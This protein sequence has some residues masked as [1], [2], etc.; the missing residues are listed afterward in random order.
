MTYCWIFDDRNHDLSSFRSDLKGFNVTVSS[1][2]ASPIKVTIVTLI[3]QDCVPTRRIDKT[4]CHP[5]KLASLGLTVGC[6]AQFESAIPLSM[7]PV[8]ILTLAFID[9]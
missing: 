2:V 7:I 8:E 1:K 9:S 4:P 5:C 6:G 3:R